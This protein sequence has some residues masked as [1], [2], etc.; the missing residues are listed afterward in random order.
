[1][2]LVFLQQLF[3][4]LNLNQYFNISFKPTIGLY[5]VFIG[6]SLLV[7]VIAGLLPSVYISLFK[8][9]DIFKNLNNIKLFKRLTLRKI[10]LVVQ[11]SVSLIFII[12]T[13]LIYSQTKHI[14]NFNYG[15]NKD[16]VINV[17]MYK[18][19]NYARFAHAASSNKD[20]VAVSACAYAPATG[21]NSST[22]VFKSENHN[23]STEANYIDIDAKC[24]DVW[25]LQLIAG[26]NLPAIPPATGEQY[27]LINQKMVA[28]MK[29][30][31]PMAAVGQRILLD[32]NNVEIAG[33]VKDF[34]FLDVS[35]G[36]EPLMLR[37]RPSE[38]GVVTIRITGKDIPA[39][40]NYLQSTWKKVN[41]DTKFEYGFLDES[42]MMTHSLL[43]D[44]AG[45]VGLLAFL[46]IFISCLGL[47]GMATYTAE[48]KQKEIG[49]RKVLGSSVYQIIL[50]L[51][52]GFMILLG[53]AVAIATPLA[54][55]LNNMW[56][57]FFA[58]RVSISPAIL[59]T[60]IG[61]LVLISFMIVFSQG[62]RA[63][64]VNPVKSLRTE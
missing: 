27:I 3:S 29:Y 24:I 46:A 51:S 60:S 30:S 11:F 59:C 7:G 39:T 38:F 28:E 1:V 37:N 53:V 63:S 42:L 36:M 55:M 10:L 18:A 9:V 22:R 35:R 16:N 45:I 14:F 25:G 40:I 12:T 4:S 64:R 26:K 52:K 2:I 41:P 50:L 43:Q 57:N 62:W 56:L 31:S 6:F 23:D 47:L 15:F 17:K 44:I 19:D 20:I 49:V 48:T 58:S 61:A 34:Q 32:N 8:P 5:L 54:Y 21:S 33:V 13:A